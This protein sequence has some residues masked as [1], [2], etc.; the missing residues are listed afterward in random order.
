MGPRDFT[1]RSHG[2]AAGTGRTYILRL[3]LYASNASG[4]GALLMY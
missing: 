3:R 4:G 2:R 1:Q